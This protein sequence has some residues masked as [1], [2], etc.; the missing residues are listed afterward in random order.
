MNH[1]FFIPNVNIYTHFTA[2]SSF[3][4]TWRANVCLDSL[5][6]LLH[7]CVLL[8]TWIF[9]Y[10]LKLR[11]NSRTDGNGQEESPRGQKRVVFIWRGRNTHSTE[12]GNTSWCFTSSFISTPWSCCA[13]VCMLKMRNKCTKYLLV[14]SISAGFLLHRKQHKPVCW[15]MCV[16][17]IF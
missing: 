5:S 6:V 15:C 2:P 13:L 8:L 12:R 17:L 10:W 9:F 7:W 1:R 4:L 11:H 16:C 3:E 14:L